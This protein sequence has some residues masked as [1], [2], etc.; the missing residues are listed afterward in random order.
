MLFFFWKEL[1][2]NEMKIVESMTN[3]LV[4]RSILSFSPWL[5]S[6][7]KKQQSK[8]NNLCINFFICVHINLKSNNQIVENKLG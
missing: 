3:R 2:L 5:V 8:N 7:K 1:V 6:L 4:E